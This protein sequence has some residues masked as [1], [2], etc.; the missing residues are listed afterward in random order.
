MSEINTDAITE[1]VQPVYEICLFDMLLCVS[2]RRCLHCS[3]LVSKQS[4]C[5]GGAEGAEKAESLSFQGTFSF[6]ISACD[7]EWLECLSGR[8][9]DVES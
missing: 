6:E 2:G 7:F 8:N 3:A 9:S 1:R 5:R 4:G